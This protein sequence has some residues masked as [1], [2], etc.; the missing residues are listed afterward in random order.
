LD[1]GTQYRFRVQAINAIG[2]GGYSTASNP[3]T[4]TA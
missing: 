2:T 4:P 3:V 1:N